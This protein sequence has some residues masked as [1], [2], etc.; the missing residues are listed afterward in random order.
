MQRQFLKLSIDNGKTILK[1]DIKK[2]IQIFGQN[3]SNKQIS[4][5]IIE[6][7]L[8]D[9][10]AFEFNDAKSIMWTVWT[11]L[12]ADEELHRAFKLL[13]KNGDG[14]LDINEFKDFMLSYGE[15]LTLGELDEMMKLFD[16]N[17]DGKIDYKGKFRKK[18]KKNFN[19]KFNFFKSL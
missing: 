16:L 4:D 5:A 14:Y 7:G 18:K 2:L 3:P 9:A 10:K 17:H 12:K 6:M 13:D 19:L 11:E 15:S 1:N 8:Q